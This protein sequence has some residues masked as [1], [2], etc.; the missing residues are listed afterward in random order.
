VDEWCSEP[1]DNLT[2]RA[3]RVVRP[4]PGVDAQELARRQNS[5]ETPKVPQANSTHIRHQ[6]PTFL[7]DSAGWISTLAQTPPILSGR[8]AVVPKAT[9]CIYPSQS[10][11]S[12]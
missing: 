3:V 5:S 2:K 9:N 7:C 4:T 10:T 11:F 6:L 12:C 8:G 1:P